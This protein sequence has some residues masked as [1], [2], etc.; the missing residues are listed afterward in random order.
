MHSGRRIIQ[1]IGKCTSLNIDHMDQTTHLFDVVAVYCDQREEFFAS[2]YHADENYKNLLAKY[3]FTSQYACETVVKQS[4]W[5]FAAAVYT[6]LVFCFL[7]HRFRYIPQAAWL[8]LPT[9]AVGSPKTAGLR[10]KTPSIRRQTT[11]D[12]DAGKRPLSG[13]FL[14]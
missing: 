11:Y 1:E 6:E 7:R 3:A 2:V 10:E 9:V 12:L 8:P 5:D 13:H 14:V 4:C